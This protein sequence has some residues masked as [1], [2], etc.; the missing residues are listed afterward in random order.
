MQ[1]VNEDADELDEGE[2]LDDYLDVIEKSEVLFLV[3]YSDRDEQKIKKCT[4]K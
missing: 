4:Q 3:R 1:K 2:Q